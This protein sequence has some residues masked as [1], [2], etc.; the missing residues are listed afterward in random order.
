MRWSQTIEI[1]QVR[2]DAFKLVILPAMTEAPSVLYPNVKN[3]VDQYIFVVT[4]QEIVAEPGPGPGDWL[5]EFYP[6]PEGKSICA[7]RF[8]SPSCLAKHKLA[9]YYSAFAGDGAA[10]KSARE[11][12]KA[13]VGALGGI[14]AKWERKSLVTSKTKEEWEGYDFQTYDVF[15]VTVLAAKSSG[16]KADPSTANATKSIVE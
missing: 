2:A 10:A 4:D 13:D 14:E 6:R 16:I 7:H 3:P 11:A 9:S 12:L 15:T 1:I 5:I 8:C